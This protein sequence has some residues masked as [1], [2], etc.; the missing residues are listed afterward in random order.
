MCCAWRGAIFL[1]KKV[2]SVVEFGILVKEMT[3]FKLQK[4]IHLTKGSLNVRILV[5]TICA[6]TDKF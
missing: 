6:H 5:E 2:F 4:C 3:D 1:H